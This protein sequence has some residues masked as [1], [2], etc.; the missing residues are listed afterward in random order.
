MN[1]NWSCDAAEKLG[2][3]A[4]VGFRMKLSNKGSGSWQSSGGESAKFGLSTHEIVECLTETA[5]KPKNDTG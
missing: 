1:L 3:E 2:I 4:E 5:S